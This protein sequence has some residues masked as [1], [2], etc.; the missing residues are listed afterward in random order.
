MSLNACVRACVNIFFIII[1]SELLHENMK[2]FWTFTVWKR[3]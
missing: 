3:G 2:M 1:F